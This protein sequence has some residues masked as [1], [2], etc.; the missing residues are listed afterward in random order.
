MRTAVARWVGILFVAFSLQAANADSTHIAIQGYDVVAY[1]TE[2]KAV[3]GDPS[4]QLPFEDAKW[5]FASESHKKMF[6]LK[7]TT[8]AAA[9]AADASSAAS[10]QSGLIT[11]AQKAP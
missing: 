7:E 11:R 10:Q 5:Q 8:T 2:G 6:A 3:K 9:A 4:Y 1:F